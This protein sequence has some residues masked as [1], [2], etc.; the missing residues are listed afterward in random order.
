MTNGT[1]EVG[2]AANAIETELSQLEQI[3]RLPGVLDDAFAWMLPDGRRDYKGF[4]QKAKVV[5]GLFRSSRLPH[6][7]RQ[8]LWAKFNDLCEAVKKLQTR[9]RE[10]YQSKSRQN[11]DRIQSFIKDA[12]SWTGGAENSSHLQHANSLLN[13]A[14][15][16]LKQE[17]LLKE[18]RQDCWNAWK[19][20]KDKVA[21]KRQDIHELNYDC[22]RSEVASVSSMATYD[23][24]HEA[25]R[26]I[27]KLQ[28]EIGGADLSKDQRRW[29]L[30]A[31]RMGP[32]WR[33]Q[34]GQRRQG[35]KATSQ[36]TTFGRVISEPKPLCFT[37]ISAPPW[38]PLALR[39]AREYS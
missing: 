3:A 2:D 25:L 26:Q 28:G 22:L 13:Q 11:M 31:A 35:L 21:R 38:G 1:R 10:A 36:G 16:L 20:A 29:L 18:H 12:S 23:D 32:L 8:R 24:P 30:V 9:E 27:K 6:A 7:D 19:E 17:F 33:A 15:E 34:L 5:S 39:G 4:W 37:R 14:M